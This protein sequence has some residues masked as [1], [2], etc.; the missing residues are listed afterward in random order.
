MVSGVI[1]DT[2]VMDIVVQCKVVVVSTC[3]QAV[4]TTEHA[5]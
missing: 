2:I 1:N 4:V 3:I 5:V